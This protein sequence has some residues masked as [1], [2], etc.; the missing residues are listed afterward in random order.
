VQR[1][2]DRWISIALSVLLHGALAA[3]LIYGWVMFRSEQHMAPTPPI[4]ATVV[5]SRAL[6][7]AEQPA[8]KPAAAPQPTAPPED[9]GPPQPSAEERAQREQEEQAKRQAEEQKAADARV[10]TEKAAADKAAA[11]R[12]AAEKAAAEKA[13]VDKAAAQ[14]AAQKAAAEKAAAA[15]AAAERARQDAEDQR[16]RE[17]DLKRSLAAEE[18]ADS[19]RNGAALANWQSMIAARITRA[20]LR[21][22]TARAGIDC[23]LNVTQ[24][25]GGEVTH[26]S[27]G[28]CNGDQAVR[29][30][31][32]AA[33]YRASPL[34]PPPDPSMFDRDLVIEFKPDSD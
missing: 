23:M 14:K 28:K 20:W 29:E 25:Q 6:K 17:A 22:P 10:A 9:V 16:E 13:A 31:I 24:V 4:Q 12:A 33:V 26:V 2:S 27:I 32:E 30:S 34:P 5:D 3:L 15:K 21:P 1:P 18:H 11:D 19:A 8:P 7:G